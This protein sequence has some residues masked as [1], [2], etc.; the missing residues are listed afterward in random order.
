MYECD[1]MHVLFENENDILAQLFTRYANIHLYV[2]LC[3]RLA[4]IV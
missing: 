3:C 2:Y 1:C 4:G